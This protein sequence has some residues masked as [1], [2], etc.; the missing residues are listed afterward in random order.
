MYRYMAK[1]TR[2]LATF[3]NNREVS[4]FL[5]AARLSKSVEKLLFFPDP[6]LAGSGGERGGGE[7]CYLN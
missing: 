7:G 3:S 2:K 4:S 6:S 5:I 1:E